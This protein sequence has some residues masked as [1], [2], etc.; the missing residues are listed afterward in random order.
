MIWNQLTGNEKGTPMQLVVAQ[1]RTLPVKRQAKGV[2]EMTFT[3]L[4]DRP[5]GSPDFQAVG[6]EF[7]T[8]ILRGVP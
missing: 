6:A 5:R 3:E 7:N 8:L 2:A 1:G 4:C